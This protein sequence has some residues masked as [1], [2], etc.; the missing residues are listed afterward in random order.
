MKHDGTG[1][2]RGGGRP[3][4]A[5][6]LIPRPT[7]PPGP[8]RTLK[9]LIYEAYVASGA[10]TLDEMATAV[11][12]D[13][14][15]AGSPSRDTINRLIAEPSVPAKQAD[16]VALLTV[17]TQMSG[18]D[19]TQGGQRAAALWTEIQLSERLGRPIKEL[20][21]YDLEVHHAITMDGATGLPAYTER[22]HDTELHR[23]VAESAAGQSRLVMLV[24]TSSTG[25][26]RACFEAVRQLPDDWR[27]W[28]PIDPERP[29]AAHADLSRVGPKTVVWLNEA[30]HYLLHLQHGEPIAA[31][32]RTLLSDPSRAP[33]LVLGTIWPGPGYY[34]DLRVT[35]P[36]GAADPH[37]QA[38]VLLAG[39]ILHVPPAFDS[40]AV[41]AIKRSQDP[42]LV[43]AAQAAQDGKI[44]QYLAAGFELMSIYKTAP[45]GPRALLEAAMDA[46][47]LGH[48][49]SLPLPFLAAAAEAY[50]TDTEWDLLPDNWL[51]QA[52]AQLTNAAKGARGPLHAQRRPRGATVAAAGSSQIYRLA[53]F[54][55]AH[56]RSTRRLD[57]VP[58][59]F[60][61]AANQHCDH[62]AAPSLALSA[63]KRG[64]A[65]TACRLWANS[66]DYAR[67]AQMLQDLARD[68]E[69]N[70]WYELAAAM[71]NAH[72]CRRRAN[73]LASSGRLEDALVWFQRAAQAGDQEALQ[74][75]GNQLAAA[76]RMEDALEWFQKIGN[77]GSPQ[78]FVTAAHWLATDGRLD[79]ALE[80]CARAVAAG[81]D[82]AIDAVARLKEQKGLQA[83][84]GSADPPSA[85]LQVSTDQEELLAWGGQLSRLGRV[86]EALPWFER[87]F[88]A[89]TDTQT[90]REAGWLLADAGHVDKALSWLERA[91]QA[92]DRD[93]LRT[94]GNQLAAAGRIDDSLAWFERAAAK[95]DVAALRSAADCL[96]AAGRLDE[97]LPW[98]D[99]A[100][101]RGD[102]LALML[103]AE[104]LLQAGRSK[105]ALARF[106]QAS[107]FGEKHALRAAARLLVEAGHIDDALAWFE[108]AAAAGDVPSLRATAQLLYT[109]GHV[110]KALACLEQAVSAG[111]FDAV[112]EAV[113]ILLTADRMSEV[114]DWV[115]RSV[116]SGHPWVLRQVADHLAHSGRTREALEWF[117]RAVSRGDTEAFRAI[118]RQLT[119]FGRL[120][121]ALSWFERAAAVGD[122][123]ALRMAGKALA[124]AKRWNEALTWLR[125][126]AAAGLHDH[127]L[128]VRALSQLGRTKDANRL[129]HYGW[130]SDG[131]IAKPWRIGPPLPAGLGALPDD[132]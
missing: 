86:S 55:E 112:N 65:E 106:Q 24:G 70:A 91:A 100:S 117:K 50:L 66:G 22:P 92:G 51:E 83:V 109:A 98:F 99:E 97:A 118:A 105:D 59:L 57:T 79:E 94:A 25:K 56:G 54:L 115:E 108:R 7:L 103:A 3:S 52:M 53:D 67:V 38:R 45:P 42:R 46:R 123:E 35:P 37:A 12:D 132:A 75:G 49:A 114:S 61:Q 41:A 18:A 80:W 131:T 128:A 30:H 95:G 40:S 14:T 62:E 31:G 69:A 77:E 125:R 2:Q 28:H 10:P 104:W 76:G 34:E 23:I 82:Y 63:E 122:I 78:A 73:H 89:G 48:P 47:R 127:N 102:S 36:S 1:A 126:A 19:G 43:A 101:G 129:R 74:A 111:D 29:Q 9:T 5:K 4:G 107:A 58:A 71:G 60:W 6:R 26:T 124:D 20:D 64:L 68:D 88:A 16:V 39:R 130:A 27:L 72:A 44:T 96:A 32:L 85:S 87:A 119:H 33:I 84:T 110:D 113:S 15:L 121:E 21:P 17:L 120:D 13:E 11:A 81:D 116:A 93:A 8:L 90:L